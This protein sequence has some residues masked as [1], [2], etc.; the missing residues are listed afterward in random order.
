MNPILRLPWFSPSPTISVVI[1]TYNRPDELR[2]CLDGFA[3]QTVPKNK[4]EIVVVDDGST[5]E[6]EPSVAPFRRTLNLRFIRAAHAGPSAARNIALKRARAPF[7]LLYDDDLR[8][9]PDLIEYC[10]DFH[11]VH[12]AEEEARLLHFGPD[13]ATADSA[14]AAWAFNTLYPFPRRAGI[15]GSG[16]FWSGT[17]TAKKSLFRHGQF[18]PAYQ[19]LEDAELGFRLSRRV[20]L[21]VHYEPRLTGTLTRNVT[22][23]QICRRQYMLGYFVHLLA[24]KH[25]GTIGVARPYDHPEKHFVT[26]RQVLAAILASARAIESREPSQPSKLLIALWSAAETHARA[27]GWMAARDSRPA[28]P[29]GTLGL[30]LERNALSA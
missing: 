1:P 3:Q 13:P 6:I 22:F 11:R 8:P 5:V 26:D 7:L 19:M 27:E 24:R 21:R 9:S 12:P 17:L 20:E 25:R 23:G 10:L 15:G 30:L 16:L 28:E 4:F 14:F 29:P 18:D 2:L